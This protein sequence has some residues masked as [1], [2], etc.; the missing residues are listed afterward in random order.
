MLAPVGTAWKNVRLAHPEI[1]LYAPDGV[2]PSRQGSYLAACVFYS[3]LLRKGVLGA[4]RL[5]LEASAAAVLQKAAQE[6]V[7]H[8]HRPGP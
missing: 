6:A 5:G 1:A 8:G 4:D 3:A 2:H 7:F